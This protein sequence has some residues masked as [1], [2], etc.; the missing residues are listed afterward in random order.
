MPGWTEERHD[1]YNWSKR[2]REKKGEEERDDAP[3]LWMIKH[4]CSFRDMTTKGII[5]GVQAGVIRRLMEKSKGLERAAN[6]LGLVKWMR[7]RD[8]FRSA[9]RTRCRRW[10][11][12]K[13]RKMLPRCFLLHPHSP[14]HLGEIK[15][16]RE[17]NKGPWKLWKGSRICLADVASL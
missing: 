3:Q 11:P 13:E 6:R 15:D 12:S 7:K 17:D 16:G 1:Q 10:M 2:E 5:R 9:A 4:S 8:F 14:P